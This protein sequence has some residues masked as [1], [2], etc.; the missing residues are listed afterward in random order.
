MT[1]YKAH[2][3]PSAKQQQYLVFSNSSINKFRSIEFKFD[4]NVLHIHVKTKK[5]NTFFTHRKKNRTCQKCTTNCY[6]SMFNVFTKA[7]REIW[8]MEVKT[9]KRVILYSIFVRQHFLG[10][11]FLFCPHR[12]ENKMARQ[13]YTMNVS[14]GWLTNTTEH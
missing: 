5:L 14:F 2:E 4:E 9:S 11:D 8:G 12:L 6:F 10:Y 1:L 13:A 7:Y 3:I